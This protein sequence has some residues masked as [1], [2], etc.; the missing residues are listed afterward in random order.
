MMKRIFTIKL[1]LLLALNGKKIFRSIMLTE[2]EDH[3]FKVLLEGKYKTVFLFNLFIILAFSSPSPQ[4]SQHG[5]PA[6]GS[7]STPVPGTVGS[8]VRRG[9]WREWRRGDPTLLNNLWKSKTPL[10]EWKDIQYF[11]VNSLKKKGKG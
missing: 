2:E 10:G 3:L 4:G 8:G 9:R 1:I 5:Q 11:C 6:A 7:M